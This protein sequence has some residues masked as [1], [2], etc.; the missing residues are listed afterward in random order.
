MSKLELREGVVLNVV[1]KKK[2]YQKKKFFMQN[3]CL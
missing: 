2:E 1:K 3:I